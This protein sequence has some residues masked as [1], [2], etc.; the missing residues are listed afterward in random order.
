MILRCIE[1]PGE[2]TEI[3]WV[4]MHMDQLKQPPNIGKIWQNQ[5]LIQ[6]GTFVE[7]IQLQNIEEL[8]MELTFLVSSLQKI[9]LMK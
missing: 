4:L 1:H 8:S 2:A 9:L 5:S 7:S 6:I 3:L